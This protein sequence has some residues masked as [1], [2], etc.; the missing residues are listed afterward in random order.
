MLDLVIRNGNIIDPSDSPFRGNIGI[1]DGKIVEISTEDIPARQ[2]IDAEGLTVS[3]GFIDIHMHEDKPQGDSIPYETFNSMALMGVTTVVGG[4]CGLGEVR[5]GSYLDIVDRQGSPVN[6]AVLVGH[7]V[8]RQLVGCTD[9]WGGASLE[10]VS[11]MASIL[12]EE[13]E[14]GALGVSF[15]LEYTPGTSTEEMIQLSRVIA[16]YPGKMVSAHYRYSTKRSPEALAEMVI[17]SRETG[18]KFQ[19]SHIGSCC[20]AGQMSQ[21]LEMIE[22]ARKFGVDVMTDVY[23]YDSFSTFIGSP[24]FETGFMERWNVGYDALGVAAG[25]YKGQRC[26]EE[27]FEELRRTAPETRIVGYVMKEE[28]VIKAMN[29]PLA[30]VASDGDVKKGVAHPRSSGTFPRVLGRYVREQKRI[31]LNTAIDKMTRMPAERLGLKKGRI[32][33]GY[34]ADLVVFDPETIIDN[35]TYE[36]PTRVPS[37]IQRVIVGGSEV[38]R[39]GSLTGV[40]PGKG[41]RF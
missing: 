14:R 2:S 38:A 1:V 27:I 22:T 33:K 34:D 21:G 11:M 41:L 9:R 19:I 5:V 37:G 29:H 7:D 13:M 20:A 26:T 39:D 30:M 25:K 10:Q 35:S 40:L 3:P 18:V 36:E 12:R 23:P 4:N 32:L 16:E 24:G 17:V 6:C 8:L 31:A 28:E 15:G